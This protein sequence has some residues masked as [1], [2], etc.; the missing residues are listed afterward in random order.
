[1]V[2]NIDMSGI[3]HLGIIEH[4]THCALV[5][6]L[7]PGNGCCLTAKGGQMLV[8]IRNAKRK[9]SILCD[10]MLSKHFN[11]FQTNLYRN[12]RI[13]LQIEMCDLELWFCH[14]THG[15]SEFSFCEFDGTVSRRED[16]TLN[17][18]YGPSQDLIFPNS[19]QKRE[20]GETW[21]KYVGAS[22]SQ[23]LI[24]FVWSESSLDSGSD[25][26]QS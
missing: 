13:S 1:M 11:A 19:P 4:W 26:V 24:D 21:G 14:F 17:C 16:Q 2:H 18:L 8:L 6:H 25:N 23:W 22:L 12:Y 3:V 7:D 10:Q 5:I 15:F 9:Y 20:L